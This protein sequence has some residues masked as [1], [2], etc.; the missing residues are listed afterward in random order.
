MRTNIQREGKHQKEKGIFSIFIQEMIVLWKHFF[1]SQKLPKLF[2]VCPQLSCFK[3]QG[4]GPTVQKKLHHSM[5]ITDLHPT[6]LVPVQDTAL[7]MLYQHLTGDGRKT[8][9]LQHKGNIAYLLYYVSKYSYSVGSSVP[10]G[11]TIV[12][13]LLE[14]YQ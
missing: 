1:Y 5:L 10:H 7:W 6:P 13:K 8:G 2:T 3:L 12:Q 4:L 9:S 11:S 14:I